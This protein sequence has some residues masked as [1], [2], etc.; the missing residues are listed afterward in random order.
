MQLLLIEERKKEGL[1]GL[2]INFRPS[3]PLSNAPPF[4]SREEGVK[5]CIG[6][7]LPLKTLLLFFPLSLLPTTPIFGAQ[8][9]KRTGGSFV[10]VSTHG[11]PKEKK[12]REGKTEEN[13]CRFSK[14]GAIFAPV[15]P[16]KIEKKGRYFFFWGRQKMREIE[17]S[18]RRRRAPL[19]PKSAIGQG[20]LYV[21]VERSKKSFLEALLLPPFLL[22][23]KFFEFALD[24]RSPTQR[25]AEK[26]RKENTILSSFIS[27]AAGGRGQKKNLSLV[28]FP[29]HTTME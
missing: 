15:P 10:P 16:A 19:L 2:V 28:F 13:F 5:I 20:F 24:T 25:E 26:K 27:D 17:S 8:E 4:N 6:G 21:Q 3:L 11:R 14:F 12:R 23:A 22:R 29:T 18:W 9:G 1:L 7:M